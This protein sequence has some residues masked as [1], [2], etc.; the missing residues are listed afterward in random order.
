MV[1]LA[2]QYSVQLAS[3]RPGRK[4]A[5]RSRDVHVQP[6]GAVAVNVRRCGRRPDRRRNLSD[7]SSA[8]AVKRC[9]IFHACF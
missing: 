9:A 8:S 2:E 4:D 1:V 7:C 5:D 3:E 6:A